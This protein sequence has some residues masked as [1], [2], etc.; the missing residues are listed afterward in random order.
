MLLRR[1]VLGAGAGYLLAPAI[2]AAQVREKL[3]VV[4]AHH[5]N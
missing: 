5:T 1:T 3:T 2:A 4:N